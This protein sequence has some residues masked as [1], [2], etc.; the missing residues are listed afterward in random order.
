MAPFASAQVNPE[1]HWRTIRTERFYIHYEPGLEHVARRVAVQAEAAYDTL[2]RFMKPPRGKID[3]IIGDN[4]DAPNGYATP[5]PTNRIGIYATPPVFDNG[6]RFTDDHINLV[7][8]HELAHVFHLDRADGWWGVAQKIVGRF[9]FFFPN[10]YHPSWITEGL[11]TY[12]ESRI[13]GAGRV[14][15]SEHDMIARSAA[16]AHR[17]PRIDQLSQANPHFPYGYSVY[18]YGSLFMDYLADTHGDSAM[19]KFVAASAR[20]ILPWSLNGPAKRAFGRSFTAA[21]RAWS[22]SLLRS[23]ATSPWVDPIPGWR[24]LTVEGAYANFPRWVNDSTLIYTGTSG[25]DSYAVRE[26]GVGSSELGVTPNSQPQTPNSRRISRRTSR[27]PN[28]VL[29][30]GDILYSEHQYSG[31]YDLRS[32]LYVQRVRGGKQRLT[33]NAR[34]SFADAR[35]G[36]DL[37][38][39]VQIVPAGTRLV[40]VTRQ[41]GAISPLTNGDIDT[42]WTEPRWS[43]DGRHVA[44]IRWTR[45]GTSALVVLDTTG[46]VAQTIVAERAVVT[47]PT[48]S[49]DG[50]WVY[51]DSDRDGISNVYRAR[52]TG[53]HPESSSSHPESSS[54]HPESSS[55]HPERSEG[56]A[57]AFERVSGARSGLFEA[58]L[59]PSG[60]QIAAVVFKADGYHIGVAPLDSVRAVPAESIAAVQPRPAAVL[61]TPNSQPATRYS[62]LRQLLPR[63]WMPFATAA[64]DSNSARYGFTTGSEDIAGRHS[65]STSFAVPTDGSGLTGAVFYRNA[66]LGR[67]QLDFH[68]AQDWENR[69]LIVDRSNGDA[70]VGTLRRRIRD[71]TMSLYFPRP[72]VRTF[73]YLNVGLGYEARDYETAPAAAIDRVDSLYRQTYYYPRIVASAGWSNAQY[74]LL[75]ISPEDGIALASTLRYRWRSRPASVDTTASGSPATTLTTSL[76]SSV[77]VYKSL[78]LPG[79]AHHVVAA[80]AAFGAQDNRGADYFEVG[81]VSGGV[82][83]VLPGYLLGEGRRTFSVRGFPGAT[84]NGIRAF[85]GSAE[86]RAPFRLPGRGVG[87]LPVFLDRMSLSLF[88]DAAS[89]WCP[90]TFAARSA[91][92]TSLCTATDV[93]FADVPLDADIIASAGGELNFTATFGTWDHP[94]LWRLGY[95]VPLVAPTGIRKPGPGAYLTIGASF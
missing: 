31:I 43:P 57:P 63:Y 8:T 17:V 22:D 76:V 30:N 89:A 50:A 12:Y 77:S 69:A 91:P 38:V 35:K 39:A 48:W 27:A 11:A 47:S 10:A 6:L 67:P 34:V 71:A 4:V 36:D 73:S 64:L 41:N 37:I 32:D 28:V 93:Q 52:F 23:A 92:A 29:S 61:P 45:G 24:D 13:T 82:L 5:Y 59:S 20:R 51:F 26:L 58:Q 2:S 16:L 40:L 56:S 94:I 75:S 14:E 72:R 88:G 15:G 95:A 86:Y 44:A 19:E 9:P 54:S 90:G 66:T 7:L 70:I 79:F 3:V 74:P 25:R 33:K 85:Q 62:A 53:S 80:R 87:T 55:S 81:G 1:R 18:A 46:R 78:D 65:Y 83:E 68:Y 42:T 49:P 84:L 60:E 21:Y